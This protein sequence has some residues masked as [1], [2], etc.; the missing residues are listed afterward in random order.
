MR[1]VNAGFEVPSIHPT[2]IAKFFFLRFVYGPD[3]FFR[4]LEYLLC[5]I[6]FN[7]LVTTGLWRH[8]GLAAIISMSPKIIGSPELNRGV[9]DAGSYRQDQHKK[10]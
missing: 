10:E 9:R 4:D 6:Q 3:R 1:C 7:G 8:I 2:P 5:I